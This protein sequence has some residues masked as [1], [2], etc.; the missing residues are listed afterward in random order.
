M[1]GNG[2]IRESSC[3]IETDAALPSSQRGRR[4]NVTSSKEQVRNLASNEVVEIL[5]IQYLEFDTSNSLN[6]LYTDDGY[7]STS[8][9]EGDTFTFYSS[10]DEKEEVG[11]VSLILYGR[12][13]AGEVMRNRFFWLYEDCEGA[14][15]G[16]RVGDGIGWVTVVSL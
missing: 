3:F 14:V 5:S 8:L 6:V 13:E 15:E 4:T 7:V 11:G 10:R 12:N 9:V 1:A 2:G 16:V